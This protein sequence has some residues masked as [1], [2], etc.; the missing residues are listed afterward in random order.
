MLEDNKFLTLECPHCGH[1]LEESIAGLKLKDSVVCT[2]CTRVYMFD[3]VKFRTALDEARNAFRK[4][5]KG[6][7]L[8]K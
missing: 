5:R 7:G 1:M 4:L 8:T 3:Q 6:L 2:R